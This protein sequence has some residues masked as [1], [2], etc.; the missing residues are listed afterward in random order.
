MYEAYV[1]MLIGVVCA[2]TAILA[3]NLSRRLRPLPY[4]GVHLTA[5]IVMISLI[6]LGYGKIPA[7]SRHSHVFIS[8]VIYIGVSWAIFVTTLLTYSYLNRPKHPP[9]T[10]RSERTLS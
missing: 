3:L 9:G 10:V 5:V 8:N 7:A 6:T 1:A 4:A 2:A